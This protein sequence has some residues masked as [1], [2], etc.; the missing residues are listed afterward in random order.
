[1]NENL[2]YDYDQR[3]YEMI[4][5]Q[6]YMMSSPSINHTRIN[7]NLHEIFARYL[8]GKTCE[9]FNQTNVYFSEK[10]HFIPD[11]IIVCDPDIVDENA[12]KGAPDLVVEILSKSTAKT[13]RDKKFFKY[14]MYGVKEYWIVD[15]FM[16][17]VEVYH[18]I[19]GKFFKSC[20][21]QLYTEEEYSLLNEKEK[22][23]TVNKIKVSIFEDLIVDVRNV[24]KWWIKPN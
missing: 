14:E 2:N 11:E 6:T 20:D 17:R 8:N 12:I 15:P 24:F 1:M 19:E 23:E 18:L 7:G 13:D 21:A 5:G 3:P 9:P 16:K 10:D 4:D 22:T